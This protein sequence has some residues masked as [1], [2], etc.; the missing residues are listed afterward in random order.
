MLS[1]SLAAICAAKIAP[2]AGPDLDETHRKAPR[3]LDRGD[4]AARGDEIDRAAELLDLQGIGH[5]GEITVDQRLHIGVRDRGRCT[6]ILANFGTD[7]GG[8]GHGDAGHLLGQNRGRAL[9]VLGV[10]VGVQEGDGDALDAQLLQFWRERAHRGFIERE[11]DGA[12]G[13]DALGHGET[14]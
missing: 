6:L 13:V 10:G 9:L 11:T 7:G 3:G 12:V 5:A 14:Q 1:P 8:Y 2:P 4:A